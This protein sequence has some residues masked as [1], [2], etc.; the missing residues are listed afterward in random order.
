VWQTPRHSHLS[1]RCS[2]EDLSWVPDPAPGG[3]L[4]S[5]S[6]FSLIQST[7]GSWRQL[8]FSIFTA[9][10]LVQAVAIPCLDSCISLLLEARL[11]YLVPIPAGM[12]LGAI[13]Q[14]PYRKSVG[15]V[16]QVDRLPKVTEDCPSALFL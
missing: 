5:F 7:S 11:A 1:L 10:A 14:E 15:Y 3:F 12:G 6:P 4:D 9:S 2:A 8:I 16:V 13:L